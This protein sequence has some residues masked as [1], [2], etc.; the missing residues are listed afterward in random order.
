[1][2]NILNSLT[3][4]APK[5]V[6]YCNQS[7]KST[8]QPPNQH[9]RYTSKGGAK[10]PLPL[11]FGCLRVHR[12]RILIFPGREWTKVCI[13]DFCSENV[14]KMNIYVKIVFPCLLSV[15][16][17]RSGEI[18]DKEAFNAI[19]LLRSDLKCVSFNQEEPMAAWEGAI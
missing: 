10:L 14:K 6:N 3:K 8:G 15:D 18:A 19:K 16:K 2:S 5:L 1:M 9:T 4:H 17:G 7:R 12:V 13:N 11:Q